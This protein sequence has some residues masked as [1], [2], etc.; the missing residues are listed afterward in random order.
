M[1]ASL[2]AKLSRVMRNTVLLCTLLLAGNALAQQIAAMAEPAESFE[3][4]RIS[5]VTF[6]PGEE[7]WALFAHNA[8]RVRTDGSDLLYNFGYFDLA[9]PGF[10]WRYARGIMRY[11]A[12]PE[13]TQ[14]AYAYYADIGRSVREQQLDIDP[15]Q[16][17]LLAQKLQQLTEPD[18]R[19][20]D[21]DY[22]FYNCST[23]VRDLLDQALRGALRTAL[24]PLPA[25]T[26]LRREAL[27]MV[28]NDVWVYLG[29]QLALGRPVD[30]RIN[31]WQAA[32]LPD[33]LAEQI[34]QMPAS[35]PAGPVLSSDVMI[36]EGPQAAAQL[37]PKYLL[38][39]GLGLLTVLLILLPAVLSS[40][41]WARLG[42]RLWLLLS[43]MAGILLLLLWCC[44]AHEPTYYNENLLL[45]L[46]S[47]LLLWRF[48][49]S[50][51]EKVAA[52]LLLLAL[53][54]ALVLKLLP[55]AQFNH[56][57]L[58][59]LLPAQ[60]AVLYFWFIS[61]REQHVRVLW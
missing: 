60:L 36:A 30:M 37:Q 32:F 23:R 4:V 38:F 55:Q 44:T 26:T 29:L 48:R 58:L 42:V 14:A 1:R 12:V 46:P 27:R 6:G 57:L 13:D 19:S 31:Q 35:V 52:W 3:P 21:Y 56:D 18:S 34:A 53:L 61:M 45:L 47:S 33:N 59:W 39:A 41:F 54:T 20:Y 22:F 15:G 2:A 9:E 49:G 7:V 28:Q 5:L 43:S 8:I 50:L 40:D 10:Y 11:Y 16:A 17:R 25:D 24:E 51:I